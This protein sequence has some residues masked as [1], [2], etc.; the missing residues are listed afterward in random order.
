MDPDAPAMMEVVSHDTATIFES[1]NVNDLV[2]KIRYIL[3]NQENAIEKSEK[4]KKWLAE[5]AT[6]EILARKTI[7][8]YRNLL[9][10]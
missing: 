2:D 6:W 3:L 10:Y 7:V 8:E 4:G 5:N 1:G 9:D